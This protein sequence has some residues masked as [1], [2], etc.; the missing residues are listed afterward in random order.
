MQQLEIKTS[1]IF[2]ELLK[3]RIARAVTEQIHTALRSFPETDGMYV[4]L[5]AVF[6]YA[7]HSSN[8]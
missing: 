3:R 6:V 2:K 1:K 8:A 4:H 7:S 5:W